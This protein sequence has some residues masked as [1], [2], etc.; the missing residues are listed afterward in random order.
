VE[1]AFR[2][3]YGTETYSALAAEVTQN[4]KSM[5][6]AGNREVCRSAIKNLWR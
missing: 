3:A 6:T 5:G 2:P 1:Q 4:A